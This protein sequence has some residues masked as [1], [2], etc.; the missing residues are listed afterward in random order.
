MDW[1]QLVPA[2]RS[3]LSRLNHWD[4][5]QSRRDFYDIYARL[6]YGAIVKAGLNEAEAEDVVQETVIAVA[7]ATQQ[8]IAHDGLNLSDTCLK[9]SGCHVR[10]TRCK[11]PA[12]G[13]GQG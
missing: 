12:D 4:D 5:Q 1:N 6:I 7:E 3:L 11:T 10:L 13:R 9:E 2:R 8:F